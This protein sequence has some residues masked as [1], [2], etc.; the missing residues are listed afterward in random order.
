MKKKSFVG[1]TPVDFKLYKKKIHFLF[2]LS[3]FDPSFPERKSSIEDD[4]RHFTTKT[5]TKTTTSTTCLIELGKIQIFSSGI[6]EFL[7]EARLGLF[8]YL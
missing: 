6:L 1:S 7:I 4:E 8:F 3:S 5:K 2:F